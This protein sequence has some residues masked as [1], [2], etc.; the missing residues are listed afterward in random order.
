MAKKKN[1][2]QNEGG[3]IKRTYMYTEKGVTVHFPHKG[4]RENE[5]IE[6]LNLIWTAGRFF[7]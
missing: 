1:T 7:R 2:N 5:Q 6:F 4:N 3:K